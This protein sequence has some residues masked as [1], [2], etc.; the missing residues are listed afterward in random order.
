[1]AINSRTKGASAECEFSN[2][3]YEWTG[4]RLVRNLEQ[5]RSGGFDL[6]VSDDEL[7]TVADAYRGLAIECKRYAK[8]TPGLIKTWWAQAMKQAQP[9]D[10]T[11]I[12]AFRGDRQDWQVITPIYLINATMSRNLG[13]E[14]TAVLSVSGFCGVVGEVV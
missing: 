6:I 10:L 2:A 11:P 9:K 4:I 12:L 3:I 14:S 1:M 13:L 5:S 7:G 8:V